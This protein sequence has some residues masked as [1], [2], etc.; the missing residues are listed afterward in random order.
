GN[1]LSRP[2]QIDTDDPH[3]RAFIQQIMGR[4]QRG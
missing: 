4:G 1:A 3:Y 2:R